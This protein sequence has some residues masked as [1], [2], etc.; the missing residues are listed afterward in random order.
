MTKCTKVGLKNHSPPVENVPTIS[1]LGVTGP[2]G[3]RHRCGPPTSPLCASGPHLNVFTA[4]STSQPKPTSAVSVT[5]GSS[6]KKKRVTTVS[7][8]YYELYKPFSEDLLRFM[9]DDVDADV[10]VDAVVD[11]APDVDADMDLAPSTDDDV[12]FDAGEDA[13]VDVDEDTDVDAVLDD[14]VDADEFNTKAFFSSM[15]NHFLHS[16]FRSHKDLFIN[17]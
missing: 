9:D 16:R 10:Y 3:T 8:T 14:D 4:A 7:S 12:Y 6:T 15:R 1:L 5:P 13:D 2:A 17:M 11:L